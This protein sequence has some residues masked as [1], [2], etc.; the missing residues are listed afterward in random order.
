MLLPDII[1]AKIVDH[2]GERDGAGRVCT[3]AQGVFGGSVSVGGKD[4]C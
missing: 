1:H 3:E 4:G 2:E